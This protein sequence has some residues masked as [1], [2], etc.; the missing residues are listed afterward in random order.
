MGF[1]KEEKDRCD[2]GRW[3]A[4]LLEH[5]VGNWRAREGV[6]SVNHCMLTEEKKNG[7]M[8]ETHPGT[9]SDICRD[10][11]GK[12]R[13]GTIRTVLNVVGH[14]KKGSAQVVQWRENP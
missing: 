6:E 11:H 13:R 3:E 2:Q 12:N 7:N 1:P 4:V 9:C 5:G 14:W 8:D 10:R